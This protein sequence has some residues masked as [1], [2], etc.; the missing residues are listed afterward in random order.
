[1]AVFSAWLCM[2]KYHMTDAFRIKI[3]KRKDVPNAI[4]TLMLD[5]RFKI[6]PP[7]SYFIVEASK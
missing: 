1:M 4:L 6:F 7:L 3:R 5:K 2:E